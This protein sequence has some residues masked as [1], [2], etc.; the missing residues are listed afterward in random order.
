MQRERKGERETQWARES[1][2][3]PLLFIDHLLCARHWQYSYDKNGQGPAFLEL[4]VDRAV[5]QVNR[6]RFNR[7]QQVPIWGKSRCHGNT[8]RRAPPQPGSGRIREGFAEEAVSYL[9]L[10]GSVAYQRGEGKSIRGHV[11]RPIGEQKKWNLW[12]PEKLRMFG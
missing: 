4:T 9:G 12:G 6:P 5:K 3:I 7:A 2:L 10:E 11:P 8:L 1:S